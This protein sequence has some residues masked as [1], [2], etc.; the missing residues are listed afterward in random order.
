VYCVSKAVGQ[1]NTVPPPPTRLGAYAHESNISVSTTVFRSA[2]WLL[3]IDFKQ[4]CS[5]CLNIMLFYQV[6][7]NLKSSE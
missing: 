5:Q 4:T 7:N 6:A 3:S 2:I 1:T